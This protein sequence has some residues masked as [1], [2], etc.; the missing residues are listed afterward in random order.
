MEKNNLAYFGEKFNQ[1]QSLDPDAFLTKVRKEGFDKFNGKGIPTHRN[2]E[3]KYSALN[4]NNL[5]K[6]EYQVGEV[7]KSSQVTKEDIDSMRLPGYENANE[8]VFVNGKYIPELSTIR[9]SEQ[10]LIIMPL[11]E[12]ENGIYRDIVKQ[13]LGKSALFIN[14]G[15]HAL[16]TSF[17]YGGVF[18]FAVKKQIIENPVYFYHISDASDNHI[19]AQP[20]SLVYLEELSKLQIAE[21]YKTIGSMDSFINEVA[22]IVVNTGAIF[23]HYKIQNDNAAASQVA[24]THVRQVGKSYAHTLVISLN[25]GTIRN[26]TNI[27]MEAEGNEAHMYG[28]YLLRGNTHV[29]NHTL[30]DNKMPNCFSNELY[31]GVI[32][33]SATGVFSGKIFVRPDAQK[34]NAYQSNNNILLSDNASVNSKPQLE[35]YA[36]DVKCS[37]GCT[38]GRLDEEALFYLQTRGISKEH[39]QAMLLQAYASSIVEQI[40]IE[41]L[42]EFA[43]QLIVDRLKD[44]S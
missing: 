19:L 25:G 3:W 26:N 12:A 4:V 14:D 29:D 13:H 10:Q 43:E 27:I 41:P 17:I 44:E 36:D 34:T 1:L 5:F 23:E 37:H 21:S 28:L 7:S 38:V 42:R 2:E 30:V 11:E 16:N 33:D 39:A 22:E 15:I 9:S 6:K 20:R 32:D 24:T 8:L 31:K 35:I 18:I 40:R